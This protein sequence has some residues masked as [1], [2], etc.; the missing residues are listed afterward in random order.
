MEDSKFPMIVL[1]TPNILFYNRQDDDRQYANNF[2][3]L[4]DLLSKPIRVTSVITPKLLKKFQVELSHLRRSV[5][6]KQGG[7][8]YSERRDPDEVV[9]E[10]A[11][12]N[13]APIVS[14]DKFRDPQYEVYSSIK[15]RVIR[16]DIREAVL[17]QGICVGEIFWREV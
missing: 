2:V 9:L 8:I 3:A 6:K 12:K 4:F 10:T 5:E 1:D 13:R 7:V 11:M 14:N 16:F 17:V 15:S